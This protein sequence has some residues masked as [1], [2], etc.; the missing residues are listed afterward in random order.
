[1]FD[2]RQK[3]EPLN[4]S[5]KGEVLKEVDAFKY[6]IASMSRGVDKDVLNKVNGEK[7]ARA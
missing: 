3:Y 4:L 1:M 7:V 5:L 6:L 2:Q